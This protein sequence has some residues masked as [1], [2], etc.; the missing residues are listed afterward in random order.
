[1]SVRPMIE[2][3]LI[4]HQTRSRAASSREAPTCRVFLLTPHGRRTCWWYVA[5]CPVCSQ[6]HLCRTRSLEL[7]TTTRRLPCGH[8]AAIAITRI[9]E[10]AG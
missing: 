7:V 2:I 3:N 4:F 8:W 1:M 6:P 9:N 5:R 10:E